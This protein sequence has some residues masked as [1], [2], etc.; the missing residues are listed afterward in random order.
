MRNFNPRTATVNPMTNSFAYNGGR[1]LIIYYNPSSFSSNFKLTAKTGGADE[2]K[3]TRAQ[4]S[5]TALRSEAAVRAPRG[6]LEV[7]KAMHRGTKC[8]PSRASPLIRDYHHRINPAIPEVVCLSPEK[9]KSIC[10]FYSWEN[11]H[12]EELSGATSWWLFAT[13]QSQHNSVRVSLGL[14]FRSSPSH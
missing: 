9:K 2:P 6:I 11:C 10:I 14:S 8:P 5:V 7:R 3:K 1:L 4:R 13:R 12:N